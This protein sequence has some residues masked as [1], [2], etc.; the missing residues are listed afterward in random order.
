MGVQQVEDIFG[1]VRTNLRDLLNILLL[2]ANDISAEELKW[3][4]RGMSVRGNFLRSHKRQ[5]DMERNH[6]LTLYIYTYQNLL[7]LLKLCM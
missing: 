1:I 7:Q 6:N 5:I 4:Q 2:E 3:R